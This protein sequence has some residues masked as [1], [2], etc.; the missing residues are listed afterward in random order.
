MAALHELNSSLNASSAALALSWASCICCLKSS[1]CFCVC[2]L[3][4]RC[5]SPGFCP[6]PPSPSCWS[7]PASA[8]RVA[9]SLIT[10]V[11]SQRNLI[12]YLLATAAAALAARG[13]LVAEDSASPE[14]DAGL[15]CVSVA[16]VPTE[17]EV[18]RRA[19]APL[20]W[21]RVMFCRSLRMASTSC[22]PSGALGFLARMYRSRWRPRDDD[23]KA[24]W[25][26]GHVL[27]LT[28]F[29]VLPS[30]GARLGDVSSMA[31]L[32]LSLSPRDGSLGAAGC[33]GLK[34]HGPGMVEAEPRGI[35]LLLVRIGSFWGSSAL[36]G[37]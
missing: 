29:V 27:S 3:T 26:Y 12:G 4:D 24:W 10:P 34:D 1:C 8:S 21:R 32:S 9:R 36:Q 5:D 11:A 33:G 2:L 13:D 7:R 31:S 18:A 35:T 20:G 14:D 17:A 16:A 6:L 19:A 22:T 30:S 28:A 25:Q 23:V 15:C 37:H